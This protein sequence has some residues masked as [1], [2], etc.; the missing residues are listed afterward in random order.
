MTTNYRILFLGD[1]VGKPGR[2]AIRQGLPSLHETYKPLFTIVNGENS[3]AGHGI[4]PDIA[5]ELF[6][7][8]VDAITLG[9]HA[10]NRKEVYDY[11]NQNHPI[12]RPYNM[13]DKTPGKGL[14][15]VQK[16]GIELAIA[17]LCGRVHL[18]GY[19]NP[20]T[21]FDEIHKNSKGHLFVDFHG[22]VTSEKIAMGWHASGRATA[23]VGTHTHVQTADERILD[24]FTA[25]ITDVGMSGPE[26]GVIG[27][28]KDPVLYRFR[29]GM[30]ARFEVADG[31]GVICGVMIEVERDSGRANHIE[32]V[33]LAT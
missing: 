4:T 31:P 24:D 18:D 25:Y 2:T 14:I 3:A 17:N 6:D 27:T 22:E 29:T 7:Q 8:G 13:P 10:F 1:I 16:D 9:N 26:N 32:R 20:F 23:V 28:H 21:A 11:L 12:A 15:Q 30:P 19:D 33:R 5:K